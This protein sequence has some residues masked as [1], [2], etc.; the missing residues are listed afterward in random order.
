MMEDLS[1]HVLDIVEN[2]VSAGATRV[3][4]S[5]NENAARDVLTLRVTDN[6]RG[7]S[8]RERARALDPFFTT[9][10]VGGGMGLGLSTCHAI[11]TAHAGT[12]T[13]TSDVGMGTTVRVELPAATA[14]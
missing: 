7:M 6:G 14:A 5:I 13:V 11:V 1:L 4:I 9:G 8:A 10:D 2:A 12:L 3:R